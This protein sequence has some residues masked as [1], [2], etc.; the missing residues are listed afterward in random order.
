MPNVGDLE[1][2]AIC[3]SLE[4]FSFSKDPFA[5]DDTFFH[6]H[7]TSLDDDDDEVEDALMVR[8]DCMR[9]YAIT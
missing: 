4:G 1:E 3:H 9:S 8:M 6:N 2:K 5:V 7:A